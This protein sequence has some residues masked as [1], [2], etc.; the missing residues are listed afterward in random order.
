[1]FLSN[2][3]ENQITEILES[4]NLNFKIHKEPMTAN[5]NGTV[6]DTPYHALIHGTSGE[7]INSVKK[8]YHVTQNEEIVGLVLDGMKQ[9]G[10]KLSV[11]KGGSLKGGRRVYLQLA[12]EGDSKV[13]NDTIKKYIT[14]IDSNDGSASLSVG[15]GDLTM[16]CSNQ[17]FQF[18][19]ANQSRFK[20]TGSMV[21]RVKELP[22]LIESALA[23][24]YKMIEL[25][26]SFQSN[27]CSRGLVDKL[28][29]EMLGRDKATMTKLEY[30]NMNTRA[31]GNM[32]ALYRHIEKEINCKG[33]NL[34]GLHSGVTSWTTHEKQAPKTENG[35]LESQMIGSNYQTNQKSLA[36]CKELIS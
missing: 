19:K 4:T 20:H 2:S 8:G 12:I 16:S 11:Q 24:S 21:E 25:Y 3:K 6:I 22:Y 17:F 10:T 31:E 18:S 27:A 7:V 34:W 14:I 9:F 33:L 35:R 36:F 30:A 32:N 1:M 26:K 23:D 13:G 29:N 28:V 15:I 5:F